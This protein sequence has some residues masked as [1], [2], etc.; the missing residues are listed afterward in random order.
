MS[1]R[2][3]IYVKLRK[4]DI[5]KTVNPDKKLIY[6]KGLQFADIGGNTVIPD[7]EVDKV[8]PVTLD[9]KY[10]GI[11]H[12]WDG[13]PNGVGKALISA[14]NNYEDALNLMLYGYESDICDG[15][16][17]I[18]YLLRGG[19]YKKEADTPPN[20]SNK[21]PT[22]LGKTHWAEYVYLFKDGEWY[23]DKASCCTFKKY[24]WKKVKEYLE[25]R[26]IK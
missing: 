14:F 15:A 19:G 17:I 7:S 26:K 22:D 10:I 23:Y 20:L 2:S 9:G 24:N 16:V 13:F 18:P 11:Y 25:K 5:G 21:I 12:H 8:P 3:M 6:A 4:E 1:V